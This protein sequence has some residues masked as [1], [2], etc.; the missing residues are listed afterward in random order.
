MSKS[1]NDGEEKEIQEA[2]RFLVVS[3]KNNHG[4]AAFNPRFGSFRIN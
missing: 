2:G 4:N 3:N 1:Q